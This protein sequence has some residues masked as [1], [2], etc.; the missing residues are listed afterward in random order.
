MFENLY[1]TSGVI[2]NYRLDQGKVQY[3]IKNDYEKQDHRGHTIKVKELEIKIQ[4]R[5]DIFYLD[6]NFSAKRH[7]IINNIK[8]TDS[9]SIL[10]LTDI[11]PF[12]IRRKIF[13]IS[14]SDKDILPLSVTVKVYEEKYSLMIVF[15]IMFSALSIIFLRPR[16]FLELF[17]TDKNPALTN[18]FLI[19]Y[20]S[21]SL[22]ELEI[23][24]LDPDKFQSEAVEA[25]RILIKKKRA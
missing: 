5:S 12:E 19:K 10:S 21:K 15:A 25:A 16:Q 4:G 23:I 8:R 14:S 13:Q 17:K 1:V 11:N 3:V 6:N 9:I 24:L 18:K 22:N 7:G 20:E 2:E